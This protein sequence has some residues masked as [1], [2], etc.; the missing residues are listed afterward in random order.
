MSI[1]ASVLFNKPAPPPMDDE[2][3]DDK[4]SGDG[5]EAGPQLFRD[6]FSSFVR[7]LI[8]AGL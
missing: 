3:D 2:K 8:L 4:S 7:S 5:S 6:G 1:K